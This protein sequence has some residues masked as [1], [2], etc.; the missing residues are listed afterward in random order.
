MRLVVYV[1]AAS[2]A[3]YA[4]M[5]SVMAGRHGIHDVLAGLA[6]GAVAGSLAVQVYINLL[7]DSY[8]V[9]KSD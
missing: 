7:T 4:S 5:S 2:M 1:A 3:I 6:I 9:S 8:P